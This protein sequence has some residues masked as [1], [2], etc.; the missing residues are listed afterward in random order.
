V[1]FKDVDRL[2][3]YRQGARDWVAEHVDPAWAEQQ[4]VSGSYHTPELHALLAGQGWL[5]AGWPAEYGG[6]DNDPDLAAALFEELDAAG[7]HLDG[8]ATTKMISNTLLHTATEEQKREYI[9]GALR[10]EIIIVLGY[11]EPDSGSDVA[12]AKTRSE[13]MKGEGEVGGE[14]QINGQKMF[15][16]TAHRATHVF[17]L[18]RS[19]TQVPKHKGLTTFMVPLGSPGVEVRPIYTLGGQRTNATFYTDVRVPESARIGP[20]DGGWGVMHVALVFE[21]SGGGGGRKSGPTLAER[22]AAWA[23]RTRRDDGTRVYDDATVK[24]RLARIAIDAEVARLLGM[25]T[26]WIS[27]TGGLPGTEGSAAKLF[28]AESAQRQ[29]WDLLDILGA[30]AVL[31]REAGD[32]P[33]TAAVEEAWRRGVVGTI[34]GG[35]SEIM[36]EIVA[37]RVL[38]LPR[39]RARS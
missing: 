34:Y 16:S 1:D 28:N 33:L 24:E 5:G 37:E 14:W 4:R 2:A 21:R 36:R 38:G 8:W 29:H 30:E 9:G 25:R 27:A 26:A 3:E 15:T 31:A 35:S 22:V 12:A 19:N 20:V 6:T 17:M 32:A 10:G 11:T 23:Q 7:L 13:R 18:T 39:V